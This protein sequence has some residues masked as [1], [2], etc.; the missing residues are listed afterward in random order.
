MRPD[1]EPG[2]W[3]NYRPP[4][5]RVAAAIQYPID[6]RFAERIISAYA[7]DAAEQRKATRT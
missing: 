5:T 4:E 1:Q 6:A 3:P 7:F 2:F